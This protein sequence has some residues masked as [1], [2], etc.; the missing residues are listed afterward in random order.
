MYGAVKGVR[1]ETGTNQTNGVTQRG[2]LFCKSRR[3]KALKCFSFDA[4]KK[5][6]TAY[7]CT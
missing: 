4:S 6:V 3:N 2:L 7:A 1:A 5:L